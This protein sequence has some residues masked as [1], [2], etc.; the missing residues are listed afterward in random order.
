MEGMNY[1]SMHLAKE[2]GRVGRFISRP[3]ESKR[4]QGRKEGNKPALVGQINM[5]FFWNMKKNK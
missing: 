4:E 5:E 1:Y 3:M 2:L